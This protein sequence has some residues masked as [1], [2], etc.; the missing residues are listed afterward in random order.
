MLL[1]Y[2]FDT[3]KITDSTIYIGTGTNVL[4]TLVASDATLASQSHS[5]TISGFDSTKN[6][7]YFITSTD[8]V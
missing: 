7:Y 2:S 6:Y 3:D 5:G 8:V 4:A 1:N